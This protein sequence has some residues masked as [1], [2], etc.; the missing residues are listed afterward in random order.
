MSESEAAPQFTYE[1]RQIEYTDRPG[2]LMREIR[3]R[4][5]SIVQDIL[6]INP[7]IRDLA[8]SGEVVYKTRYRFDEET[9]GHAVSLVLGER[10]YA[11][12]PEPVEDGYDIAEIEPDSVWL[13]LDFGLVRSESPVGGF[14]QLRKWNSICLAANHHTDGA[15]T[16]GIGIFVDDSEEEDR[17]ELSET[18]DDISNRVN[19]S[20]FST[21]SSDPTLDS[22]CIVPIES[23]GDNYVCIT[24][25]PA[26][27]DND[28]EYYDNFISVVSG[29]ID[30]RFLDLPE[31]HSVDISR[32]VGGFESRTVEFKEGIPPTT[33]NLAEDVVAFANTDGGIV[34]I[35]INDNGEVNTLDEPVESVRSDTNN[36]IQGHINNLDYQIE[37]E[38]VDG[39]QVVAVRVPKSGDRLHNVHGAFYTRRGQQS[40]PMSFS[41]LNRFF[42]Q[43]FVV[44]HNLGRLI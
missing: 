33:R 19:N 11:T 20:L 6:K 32:Y 8:A 5:N 18:I 10:D 4:S 42:K 35:G 34:V 30:R 36:I 1:I 29:E 24:E 3:M 26:P 9:H 38:E 39:T 21:S 37:I 28:R 7:T 12:E 15:V 22:Y 14:R 43:K 13:A 23:D 16:G 40:I 27:Q 44:E 2:S 25:E 41:D 17:A 31:P